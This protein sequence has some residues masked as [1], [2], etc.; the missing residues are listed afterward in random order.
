MHFIIL[1]ATISLSKENLIT[2]Y[3]TTDKSEA[4]NLSIIIIPFEENQRNN[5]LKTPFGFKTLRIRLTTEKHILPI[6]ITI[7]RQNYESSLLSRTPFYNT[8]KSLGCVLSFLILFELK[9][10]NS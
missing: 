8:A 9:N 10:N 3:E 2:T 1:K 4:Q 5:L 7:L 6:T